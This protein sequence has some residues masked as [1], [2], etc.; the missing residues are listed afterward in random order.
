MLKN[1]TLFAPSNDAFKQLQAQTPNFT[2]MA[3]DPTFITNLLMYHAI[4]S[5]V[6]SSMFNATP[7]FVPT[8]LSVSGP[9]MIS[10]PSA[11][12]KVSLQLMGAA[13]MVFSGFKQMSMVVRYDQ[14]FDG[15]VVHIIDKVLTLPG[16]TS[17]TALDTGLTSFYGAVNKTAMINDV[18]MLQDATIFVPN[19]KAFEAVGS[20]VETASAMELM[21]VLGYHVVK[22]T[23]MPGMPMF[24]TMLEGMMPGMTGMA[25]SM[26]MSMP[27]MSGMSGTMKRHEQETMMLPTLAGGNLTVRVDVDNGDLFINSAKVVMSDIITSNGVIHVLDK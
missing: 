15:G 8:L 24:S 25:G 11:M 14:V 19:N 20:L 2:A 4:P 22:G 13:A 3:S 17:V 10:G 12:Q 1:V 16:T 21:T 27:G 5:V 18:D 23:N 7:M 26:P 6:M 9:G